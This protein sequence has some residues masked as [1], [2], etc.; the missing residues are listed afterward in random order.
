MAFDCT[1]TV[2]ALILTVQ[3]GDGVPDDQLVADC[4]MERRAHIAI[5]R[6]DDYEATYSNSL[7]EVWSGGRVEP[8]HDRNMVRSFDHKWNWLH[9]M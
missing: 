8:I 1:S 3:D 4:L 2:F 5:I 7:S 9:Q 6:T